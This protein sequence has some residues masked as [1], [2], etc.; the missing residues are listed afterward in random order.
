M[1]N[2]YSNFILLSFRYEFMGTLW[3]PPVSCIIFSF[4][5]EWKGT[6]HDGE[7]YRYSPEYSEVKLVKLN[8][9]ACSI[10]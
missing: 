4:P 7:T 6:K 1:K 10:N 9:R 5:A 2:L 8:C 3:G